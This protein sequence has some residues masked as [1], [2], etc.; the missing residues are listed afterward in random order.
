[1]LN[2]RHFRYFKTPREAILFGVML[3]LRFGLSFRDEEGLLF[4]WGWISAD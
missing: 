3:Y 4:A 1:M 2:S